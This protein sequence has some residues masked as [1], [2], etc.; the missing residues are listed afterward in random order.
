LILHSL[1]ESSALATLQFL[2]FYI[3]AHRIDFLKCR[4]SLRVAQL[5]E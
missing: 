4:A 5:F 1:D 2:L 3:L